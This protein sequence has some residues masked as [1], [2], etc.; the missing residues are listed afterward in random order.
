MNDKHN[1]QPPQPREFAHEMKNRLNSIK[2]NAEV[3]RVL[4]RREQ[5]SQIEQAAAQIA[6]ECALSA[7][8][9]DNPDGQ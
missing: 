1:P 4:A 5:N 3:I 8:L 6:E 2:M 9:I 7:A